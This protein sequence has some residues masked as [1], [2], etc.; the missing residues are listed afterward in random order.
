M[1]IRPQSPD[2]FIGQEPARRILEGAQSTEFSSLPVGRVT[3]SIGIATA[4]NPKIDTGERLVDA[5]D[6]AMYR[7]KR[8]GRNRIELF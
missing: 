2:D 8:A 4:P 7:A 3:I 6:Q 5:S 1:T